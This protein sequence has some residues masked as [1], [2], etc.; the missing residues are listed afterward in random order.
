M[1]H[2]ENQ[3]RLGIDPRLDQ[4]EWV[5]SSQSL[6]CRVCAVA[7]RVARQVR[8]RL[9]HLQRSTLRKWLA[10]LSRVM[11]QCGSSEGLRVLDAKA[12]R[13]NPSLLKQRK[14]Q[15]SLGIAL[16]PWASSNRRAA[17][18]MRNMLKIDR[19]SRVRP[20]R[21]PQI[22]IR[23][24][25]RPSTRRIARVLAGKGWPP[26]GQRLRRATT[27]VAGSVV[28]RGARRVG[29]PHDRCAVTG[30]QG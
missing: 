12:H 20:G 28:F 23:D 30:L 25:V 11:L 16:G 1:D 22:V 18:F 19:H 14:A 27:R 2:V 24:P 5:V 15:G 10:C 9:G 29:V 8:V 13:H 21:R 26:P 3:A 4:G 17:K 6:A 7:N